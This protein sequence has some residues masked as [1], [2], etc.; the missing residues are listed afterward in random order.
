MFDLP[1]DHAT[2]VETYVKDNKENLAVARGDRL[3]KEEDELKA[4][5]GK[6][7]KK[8]KAGK[9]RT[10]YRQS[11]PSWCRNLKT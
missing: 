7:K 11:L 10:L 9:H 3:V 4:K 1:S 6:A 8:S 5:K 2:I